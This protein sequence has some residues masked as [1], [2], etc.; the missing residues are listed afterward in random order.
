MFITMYHMQNKHIQTW[1]KEDGS[2]FKGIYFSSKN[3][4]FSSQDPHWVAHKQQELHFLEIQCHAIF[5]P[6]YT[7]HQPGRYQH[8]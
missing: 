8:I 6:P 5:W 1:S 2:E 7:V 3:L 4:E